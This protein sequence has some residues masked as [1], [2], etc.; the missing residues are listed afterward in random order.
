[1]A[2]KNKKDKK[3]PEEEPSIFAVIWVLLLLIVV[4][5]F[6]HWSWFGGGSGSDKPK[7]K[8]EARV[9][10]QFDPEIRSI[11][12]TAFDEVFLDASFRIKE[13]ACEFVEIDLMVD[14][15]IT[16]DLAKRYAEDAIR[17]IKLAGLDTPP[18]MNVG[19]GRYYYHLIMVL[20]NGNKYL[21]AS[22]SQGAEHIKFK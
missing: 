8:P 9:C 16:P 18:G 20:P 11:I 12:Q 15:L 5:F 7:S 10:K 19:S 13:G 6:L 17:A 21:E 22:K 1:M 14:Y 3:N 2:K 4:G